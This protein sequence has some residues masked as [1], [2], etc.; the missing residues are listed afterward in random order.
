M[1][2]VESNLIKSA[3]LILYRYFHIYPSPDVPG[4][5]GSKSV[6]V[7]SSRDGLPSGVSGVVPFCKQI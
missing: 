1:K 2:S 3:G 7:G 6:K 4:V 5:L